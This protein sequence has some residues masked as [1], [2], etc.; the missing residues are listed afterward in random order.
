MQ[1]HRPAHRR[2]GARAR[3]TAARSRRDVVGLQC[4]FTTERNRTLRL[5]RA[6]QA[7][8][9]RTPSSSSAATTP[10]AIRDWFRHAGD[11]RHRDRR[12]RGGDAAAGRRAGA[13]AA[14]SRRSPGLVLTATA[15]S[16]RP[17][18]T[19]RRAPNLDTLPAAGAPPDRPLRA[20]LLH[21]LPQAAGADGDRPRLPVQVQLL[22]GVEVPRVA[23]SARSRPSAWCAELQAIE[24]PNIF[25][26]DDIFWMNVKR[27]EEMAQADQGRG[28]PQVLHRADAHRHHLQVPAPDRDVEGLRRPGDLPRPRVGRPTRG[29]RRS[30][31]RTPPTTTCGH[32]HPQGARRRLHAELHRRSGLGPRRLHSACATGSTTMGAYNSGFSILTPLPGTDLWDDRQDAT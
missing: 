26:T 22:L 3:A 5:A 24:A 16:W 27:G 25:I 11:R 23:P 19:R 10:R 13:T 7:R 6:R 18:A 15:A 8:D 29:S 4:N 9:A 20:T 21:Q 12:R 1:G 14:T 31:R 17:P 2:R 30:T 32:R 28:H